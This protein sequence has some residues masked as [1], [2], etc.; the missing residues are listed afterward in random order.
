M[1]EC[2][3][4]LDNEEIIYCEVVRHWHRLPRKA[5]DFPSLEVLKAKSDGPSATGQVGSTPAMAEGV[6]LNGL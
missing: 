4:W 2:E 6:V 3:L 1:K 5:M